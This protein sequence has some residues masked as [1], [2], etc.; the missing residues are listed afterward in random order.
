MYVSECFESKS[1][2]CATIR[3]RRILDP[4]YKKSDLNKVMTKQWQHLNTEEREILLNLLRKYE[5]LFDGT[6]GKWNNTPVDLELRSDAKPVC[7]RLYPVLRLHEDMFIN[8]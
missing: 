7:L 6:L 2:I 1:A 5:D 8:K 4:K 3:M